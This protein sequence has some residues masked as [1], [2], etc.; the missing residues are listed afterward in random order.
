[1]QFEVF[2]EEKHFAV[3]VNEQDIID[4]Q[5]FFSQMD[6]DMDNGW[7]MGPEFIHAP[8]ITQRCQ[9]A[10]E[11]LMLAIEARKESLSRAMAAY[12]VWRIPS[13]RELHIDTSG[14]PLLTEIIA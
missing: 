14:E 5:V 7:R 13:I 1:M 10:A 2:F 8:D 12:I 3:E 9:I 6:R 4:G 11:R